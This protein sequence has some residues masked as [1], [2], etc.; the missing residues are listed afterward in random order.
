MSNLRESSLTSPQDRDRST[1]WRP[2]QHAPPLTQEQTSVA[3]SENNNTVFVDKFPQVERLFADPPIQ[4]QK[5]GLISFVPAKGATPNSNGVY[6]FAKLRG[7][8]DTTLESNER[9]EYIIR[10][11]DSYHQIF[12]TYVGRPFPITNSSS[13]SAETSEVD[14]KKE[15][16]K[17]MSQNIKDKRDEE[18]KTIQEIKQ[19]EEA[20]L[21]ESKKAQEDDGVSDVV[22]D[23]YENYITLQVKKAQLSWTYLEHIKKMEEIKGI[24]VKTRKSLDQLDI[25]HPTFKQQYFQKYMDARKNSGLDQQ[26]QQDNFIKFM[27]EDVRLPGIDDDQDD[28]EDDLES[29]SLSNSTQDEDDVLGGVV[30]SKNGVV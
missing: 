24:I 4:L 6:G 25:D 3:M 20:L 19:K 5:Y 21:A 10:N 17:N 22:L 1:N 16:V 26:E 7:N 23:P 2:N 27:V 29:I 15:V 28:I 11:V 8:Y 13:Y 30:E 14:I 9:A 12:H 18:L